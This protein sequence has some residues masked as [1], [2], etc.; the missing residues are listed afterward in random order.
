MSFLKV[1][2]HLSYPRHQ[3][4]QSLLIFTTKIKRHLNYMGVKWLGKDWISHEQAQG[5]DWPSPA[6][7]SNVLA[8]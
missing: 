2:F 1:I 3:W 4:R 7:A 6:L 5:A 8:I